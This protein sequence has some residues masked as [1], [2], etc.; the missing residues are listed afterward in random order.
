MNH[1][2]RLFD[3]T[4]LNL[5]HGGRGGLLDRGLANTAW[6]WSL[7]QSSALLDY[8]LL[9]CGWSWE[10]VGLFHS[11]WSSV[12]LLNR[13]SWW[14][15]GG[16]SSLPCSIL[17]LPGFDP[18]VIAFCLFESCLAWA[19][20]LLVWNCQVVRTCVSWTSLSLVCKMTQTYHHRSRHFRVLWASSDPRV[21]RWNRE[22]F[23]QPWS[24]SSFLPSWLII[25]T[26]DHL[27]SWT[28][29]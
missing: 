11:S 1:W 25:D 9:L 24:S 15:R 23:W 14:K 3:W 7:L 20:W 2:R 21:R 5:L 29:L 22:S 16:T 12:G 28:A 17:L 26:V 19:P 27:T 8:L 10:L 13:G 18:D 6:S 4:L